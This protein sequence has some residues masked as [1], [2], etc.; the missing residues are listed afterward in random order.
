MSTTDGLTGSKSGRVAI[1]GIGVICSLGTSTEQF[2]ERCLAGYAPVSPIPEHWHRYAHYKSSIWSPLPEID[3]AAYGLTRVE[4]LQHDPV[5]LLTICAA[6]EAIKN[7]GLTTTL[8]NRRANTF[9]IQGVDPARIGVF[10]GTG[11]GGVHSFSENHAHQVLARSTEG[12]IKLADAGDLSRRF[13]RVLEGVLAQMVFPRRFNPFVVSM[14]MP[15]AVSAILGIKY[16]ITGPNT[17]YS[18]ACAAGTAAIGHAFRAIRSGTV[19]IALTGGCEYLD[20]HYGGAFRGFDAANTLVQDCEERD[21]ANRPFDQKRS[22]F[23]FSQGAAALLVLEDW[24][25]AV[26]RGV[27]I[28]AEISGYA[29][30]FDAHNMMSMAPDGVQIERM[31][32]LALDDAQLEPRDIQYVNAH[33]T[34]TQA[35]DIT[36]AQV[37]ERVFGRS[38][39]VNSTKSLVGHTIGASGALEAAVTALSLKHATTHICRNLEDPVADLN[40]VRACEPHDIAAALSQSFAFGGHNAG[41][42]MRRIDA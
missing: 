2:W 17:T 9:T 39:L 15:N 13:A 38:V 1:S 4:R 8:S 28:T 35:N 24:D 16:S 10:M 20:D 22:G 3:Y 34:G 42:V 27:S 11:L 40:F 36:E 12:L 37:I 25:R 41:L 26:G 30:N 19:D 29:E 32:R 31:V 33:G 23:L 14:L 21:R 5:S 6:Q 18:L 7:A